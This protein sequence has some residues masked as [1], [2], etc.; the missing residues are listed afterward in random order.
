MDKNVLKR[1]L[2]FCDLQSLGRWCCVS[3]QFK[4]LASDDDLYRKLFCSTI[5]QDV[6]CVYGDAG[7][8]SKTWKEKCKF[9]K[10][11]SETSGG[12]AGVIGSFL[13]QEE[14]HSHIFLKKG[15]HRVSDLS[16]FSDGKSVTFEGIEKEVVLRGDFFRIRFLKSARFVNIQVD[17]ILFLGDCDTVSFRDC[18]FLIKKDLDVR[19][20]G[21]GVVLRNVRDGELEDCLFEV[22]EKGQSTCFVCDCLSLLL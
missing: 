20:T 9:V 17:C 11:S 1:I 16:A 18:S 7:T 8:P 5:C 13:L 15:V 3:K 22:E 14:E 6:T 4:E 10:Q 2:C 21:F 19:R 12:L